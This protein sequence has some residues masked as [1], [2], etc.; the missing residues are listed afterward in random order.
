MFNGEMVQMGA[1][2]WKA[3]RVIRI[4][5]VPALL[6]SAL[7]Q[8]ALIR[9][10][11]SGVSLELCLCT[12]ENA[13]ALTPFVLLRAQS[14]NDYELVNRLNACADM[15]L[16]L[17]QAAGLKARR[18]SPQN[19]DCQPLLR[20][21]GR[22]PDEAVCGRG[23]FPQ[24]ELTSPEGYY[25][26][27]RMERPLELGR[28]AALLSGYANAL[29]SVQ[30]NFTSLT[31]DEADIAQKN[32]KWFDEKN[33]PRARRA[34]A[35]FAQWTRR[36]A[37]FM[38]GVFCFG[39]AACV[40]DMAAQAKLYGLSSYQL[41][42]EEWLSEGFWFESDLLGMRC[43]VW[44]GHERHVLL[45]TDLRRML[46]FTHLSTLEAVAKSFLLPA[47]TD[48]IPG[49]SRCGTPQR[50]QPLPEKLQQADGV[51]LGTKADGSQHVHVP[52]DALTRHGA[53]VGKP[54]SGKTTF[55]L[56]LLERL[57]RKGIPFLIIE[58][59]KTEYRSLL[60]CIPALRIYTPGRSEVSPLQ[61]NLFLPP[62][63]I[64]MEEYAS[65]LDTIFAM[66]V[67]TRHPLDVIF[68]QVIRHCYARYGWR[69]DSTRDTP[70]VQVFG[71]HEFI[72]EF[73]KY[74]QTNFAGDE[75]T[76]SNI[77]NGGVVRLMELI[78]TH[79][80]LFDT[81]C[82]PD[83]E[84][85]LSGPALIE[86]D[87]ITDNRQKALIM[88]IVLT[89][90][91]FIVRKRGHA[92]NTLRNVLML[93]EAHLLLGDGEAAEQG[94]A[95]PQRAGKALLQNM[96][97][98]SRSYGMALLFGDQSPARLTKEILDN[99]NLKMMFRLDSRQDRAM[100]A[101]T[102]LLTDAM[103]GQ[104]VT[105]P[106]GEG[107]MHCDILP[108]PVRL[109]TPDSEKEL[110]LDKSMGDET[111]RA[112]MH[113]PQPAPYAQ[114]KACTHCGG[115]CDMKL[116]ADARFMAETLLNDQTLQALLNAPDS[117]AG[118]QNYFAAKLPEELQQV[119][120]HFG[121]TACETDRLNGCVRLH[122]AR[123]LQLT[124]KCPLTEEELLQGAAAS[125]QAAEAEDF[126][127]S[128]LGE[129]SK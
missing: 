89:Q 68:P 12:D 98:I 50:S 41:P 36:G 95:D 74:V 105:L 73:E 66:A 104:M 100:L 123:M 61:L 118:I 59:A 27:G 78:N 116:R 81:H 22:R 58:P 60:K 71:M 25:V 107:Y 108:Q 85:M 101:E 103:C 102:A 97:L 45:R 21:L 63:G 10:Q 79:P 129:N 87:A 122:L 15:L 120:Q 7:A 37:L 54:G 30:M 8:D 125:P 47:K 128:L 11:E 119:Q 14:G 86:L 42:A 77:R 84:E 113:A 33:D 1:Q 43:S 56:G 24:E 109:V 112:H 96:T 82:A 44:A 16:R 9:C 88:A 94:V 67:S 127:R 20:L 31:D 80:V 52:L 76:Q 26:P 49:L 40:R 106:P 115:A 121:I 4:D 19:T 28:L 18:L 114:C 2:V 62:R 55:A 83:F 3:V 124:G 39:S 92:G 75:E 6:E 117:R 110:G 48:G 57:H 91:M 72:R 35:I 90:A 29:L 5:A 65:G 126:L 111:V 64:T 32:C 34:Q 46:R 99:V 53:I 13:N 38:T 17:L 69:P 70:G 23:F 93:D 51:Y